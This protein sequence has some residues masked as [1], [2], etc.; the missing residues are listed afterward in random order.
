MKEI[1]L[2]NTYG[3]KSLSA[4]IIS[5]LVKAVTTIYDYGRRFATGLLR[6]KTGA[7]CKVE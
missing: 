1:E 6:G 4:A 3:G 2:L 5:A 7:Y